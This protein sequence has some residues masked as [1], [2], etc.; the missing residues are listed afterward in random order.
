MK[1]ILALL[2]WILFSGIGLTADV[3]VPYKQIFDD[4]IRIPSN[5]TIQSGDTV[6]V[7]NGIVYN[8]G[9]VS[10]TN[11]PAAI[12]VSN[13]VDLIE[14]NTSNWNSAT[15][16]VISN[17]GNVA[18]A[19]S[20]TSNWNK[21]TNTIV[22]N[23]V[24]L[25]ST[26]IL[27]FTNGN[28]LVSP[29][30]IIPGATNIDLGSQQ[31][32]WRS[33]W[34]QSNS[35]HVGNQQIS[36][37]VWVSTTTTTSRSESN[38]NNL[39]SWVG[40]IENNLT[41]NGFRDALLGSMYVSQLESGW[42][43]DF[44]DQ[45]GITR[46][47]NATYANGSYY[48]LDGS[49]IDDKTMFVL[50]FDGTSGSSNWVDSSTYTRT[51]TTGGGGPI[52]TNFSKF[53]TGSLYLDGSDDFLEIMDNSA[54]EPSDSN[55][56]I[57]CWLYSI[58]A[59]SGAFIFKGQNNGE[60]GGGPTYTALAGDTFDVPN[61]QGWFINQETEQTGNADLKLDSA[62]GTKLLT[63][64]VWCHYAMVRSGS[65]W[66]AYTNGVLRDT[67]SFAGSV[68][69][70][71]NSW[72]FGK[73]PVDPTY[74]IN[75]YVDEVRLS[76]GTDRGWISGFT[77]P[78]QAY[79]DGGTNSVIISTNVYA[80]S[81]PTIL[82]G[83]LIAHLQSGENL[84]SNLM[85]YATCNGGTTWTNLILSYTAPYTGTLWVVTGTNSVNGT[86]TNMMYRIHTYGTSVGLH[87]ASLL[88]R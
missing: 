50:H 79:S 20:N 80:T 24:K 3:H 2:A 23:S 31:D 84:N 75:A 9:N 13:R 32:P 49:G 68:M 74:F 43:D 86:G 66:Y 53:G 57:E 12:V 85:M 26:N 51:L 62:G 5:K 87:A 36:E 11:E 4:G 55:F 15:N 59:D 45:S 25:N 78:A 72:K 39:E 14:A 44:S 81:Q 46:T 8:Q 40:R 82:K 60:P 69:D 56:V 10:L 42:W 19:L 48:L 7:S 77:P 76:I 6:I 64:G 34:F 54:L 63:T 21:V 70:L 67:G 83:S 29:F 35:L 65:S 1:K 33:G 18:I 16:W 22:G 71:T 27:I 38:I 28:T 52:I 58:S 61:Y 17:S 47:T 73:G 30:A 88:W 41:I 37:G